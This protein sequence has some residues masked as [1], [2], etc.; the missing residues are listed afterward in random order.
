MTALTITRTG[1][2]GAP[3]IIGFNVGGETLG[4]VEIARRITWRGLAKATAA[5]AIAGTATAIRAGHLAIAEIEDTR[6][7]L[8]QRVDM[9]QQRNSDLA[10]ALIE[11]QTQPA[12][13][14]AP[15]WT[16]AETDALVELRAGGMT[17]GRIAG[18]LGTGRTAGAVGAKWRALAATAGAPAKPARKGRKAAA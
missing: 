4:L 10:T 14:R 11:A 13:K 18:M 3:G 2:P 8:K 1:A 17:Y 7:Q 15:R 9:L 12:R 16:A 5:C 6:T